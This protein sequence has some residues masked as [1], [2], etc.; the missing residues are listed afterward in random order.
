[1]RLH[2]E[3]PKIAPCPFC[4]GRATPIKVN[5]WKQIQCTSCQAA[6][7]AGGSSDFAVE[8]WNK[9]KPTIYERIRASAVA[10]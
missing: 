3:L 1:M 8:A 5:G 9:R 6:G 4:G 7:P 2:T 10:A